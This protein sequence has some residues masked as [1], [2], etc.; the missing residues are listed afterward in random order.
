[1][2]AA[3]PAD[4]RA[5]LAVPGAIDRVRAFL[6]PPASGPVTSPDHARAHLAPLSCGDV[7]TLSIL[8]LDRRA[9]VLS[10][11]VLAVGGPA[12]CIVDV[13]VIAR[14]VLTH[15]R[16]AACIIAHNHPAGDA[17][18]SRQDYDVTRRV[19]KALSLLGLTLH[20][21]LTLT[22][23]GAYVSI[24]ER[25]PGAFEPTASPWLT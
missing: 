1:M 3:I 10:A 2:S 25:D 12:H 18:P 21:H 15:A 7:E 19:S 9:H 11:R 13:S 23:A 4:V 14:A 22:D 16:G 6:A 20:D 24:R 5:A 8:I 17:T